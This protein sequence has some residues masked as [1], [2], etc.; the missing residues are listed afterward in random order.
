MPELLLDRIGEHLVAPIKAMRVV[1]RREGP[2]DGFAVFESDQDTRRLAARIL[3]AQLAVTACI[4][5]A[6]GIIGGE[7]PGWSALLGGAIGII[8]NLYMTL[9]S[10]RPSG[11]ARQAVR[12]LYVG[13]FVKVGLT[14][15]L[16]V[17]VA[18]SV[19]VSWPALLGAYI[20]TLI[21]FWWVPFR[22]M[23]GMAGKRG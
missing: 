6:T 22:A 7:R 23:S 8:A 10:L 9:T 17:A 5:A 20:A 3:V 16:F 14:V 4:A 12:R 11:N 2:R 13:Q 19:T 18:R 1:P 21:V 15:A